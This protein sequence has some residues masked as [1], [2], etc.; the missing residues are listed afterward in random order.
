MA[1][2]RHGLSERRACQIVGQSRSTQ[3]YERRERDD[4]KPLRS[5]IL[6]AAKAH[7]RYGSRRI[8]VIVRGKGFRVNQ[9]RVARNRRRRQNNALSA[10][11]WRVATRSC[12]RAK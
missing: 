3:R 11:G 8:R 10:G 9:K 12:M 7:P 5:A 4:E 6:A 1:K 2:D